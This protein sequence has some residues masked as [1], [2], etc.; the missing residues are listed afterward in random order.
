VSDVSDI[1]KHPKFHN[2]AE[3]TEEKRDY[4]EHLDAQ[5]VGEVGEVETPPQRKEQ[6]QGLSVCRDCVS[7]L[8]R[9]P[10]WRRWL[11]RPTLP[12]DDHLVCRATSHPPFVDYVTG[13]TYPRDYYPCWTSNS[14]GSCQDFQ[15]RDRRKPS[16]K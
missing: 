15:L 9:R 8:D 16:R 4:L 3:D 11:S 12:L 6:P 10:L 14:E 2:H 1:T 13:E 5:G 7:F